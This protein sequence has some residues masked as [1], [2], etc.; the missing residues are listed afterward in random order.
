[1]KYVGLHYEINLTHH[2]AEKISQHT[3][4]PC[5]HQSSALA[6]WLP[7]L[8]RSSFSTEVSKRTIFG[9]GIHADIK[10]AHLKAS[11]EILE[12]ITLFMPL[13]GFHKATDH[14][15][16]LELSKKKHL[17]KSL[18]GFRFKK[19]QGGGIYYGLPSIDPIPTE[20]NTSGCAGH[21][22]RKKAINSA[23]LELIERDAFLV[24]WINT[25][26]PKRI[27][28]RDYKSK[29]KHTQYLLRTL[30]M[31][32]LESYLFDIS[33]DIDVPVCLV[34]IGKKSET[35]MRY[36]FGSSAGFN[37][38][39]VI[40]NAIAE[41]LSVMNS[42]YIKDPYKLENDYTP[43]VSNRLG[44]DERMRI[45][46]TDTMNKNLNFLFS[47]SETTTPERFIGRNGKIDI[48][49]N[50]DPAK[51]CTY[52]LQIFRERHKKDTSWDIFVIDYSNKLISEF[53]YYVVRV[54]CNALVPLYLRE[55]NANPN[56]KRYKQ[57]TEARNIKEQIVNPWPHP[58]P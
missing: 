33:S 27:E 17:A 46:F 36:F 57:F 44:Q 21:F 22:N 26:S 7:Q 29:N 58:F 31:Y 3:G 32:G 47:N 8:N 15:F 40:Q 18:L 20:R 35:G 9:T 23:I 48:E 52:L 45:Y 16:L 51:Q 12:R 13:P 42:R 39:E 49:L 55:S 11:G 38:D 5:N 14:S 2:L 19:L 1:M 10:V 43:F 53:G 4:V 30:R 41:A 25:I 37:F 54:V 56:H 6:D 34:V 28:I 50:L 24:H